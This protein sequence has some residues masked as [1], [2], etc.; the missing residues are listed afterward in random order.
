VTARLHTRQLALPT[1]LHASAWITTSA[2]VVPARDEA[3]APAG[4]GSLATALSLAVAEVRHAAVQL[5]G[6]GRY[7]VVLAA[8]TTLLLGYGWLRVSNQRAEVAT[9]TATRQL[10]AARDVAGQL[11]LELA[12]RTAPARL[13][14]AADALGL[15]PATEVITLT[16]RSPLA[17]G[18]LALRDGPGR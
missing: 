2:T 13:D 12:A 3:R 4:S 15:V 11:Q 7:A 9:S 14:L 18:D 8:C 16:G 10:A 6:L 5:A 17:L 1:P